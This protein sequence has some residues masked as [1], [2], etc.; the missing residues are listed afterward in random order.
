MKNTQT[1]GN[2]SAEIVYETAERLHN[3]VK[4]YTDSLTKDF[5]HNYK[6]FIE[7]RLVKSE[8]IDNEAYNDATHKVG[9]LLGKEISN[10]H[11]YSVNEF[12]M[13]GFPV[14]GYMLNVLA[15]DEYSL[16][17]APENIY[18]YAALMIGGKDCLDSVKFNRVYPNP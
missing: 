4:E 7:Q 16:D 5:V 14:M 9:T 17:F 6:L 18:E 2:V 15:V 3:K 13:Y 1:A 12:K 10:Y 11:N 8:L